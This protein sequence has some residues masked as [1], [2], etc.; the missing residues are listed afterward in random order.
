METMRAAANAQA[1]RTVLRVFNSKEDA[2]LRGVDA[3]EDMLTLARV[4]TRVKAVLPAEALVSAGAVV[5]LRTRGQH[6]SN[7]GIFE[8]NLNAMSAD[9]MSDFKAELL[10][11]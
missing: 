9:D 8:I 7:L 10:S 1:V 11:A 5:P 2:V 3:K 6:Q 4:T